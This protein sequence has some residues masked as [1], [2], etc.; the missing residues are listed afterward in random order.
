LKGVVNGSLDGKI[1]TEKFKIKRPFGPATEY[2]KFTIKN[3]FKYVKVDLWYPSIVALKNII[4]AVPGFQGAVGVTFP[5]VDPDLQIFYDDG[6]GWIQTAAASEMAIEYGPHEEAFS[7]VYKPGDWRIGVTN[8]P[9]EGMES[10]IN[11]GPLGMVKWYGSLLDAMKSLLGGVDNFNVEVTKYPGTE[12]I[13][14]DHPEF[15]CRDAVFELTWDNDDV[16]LGLSLIGPSGE[17]IDSVLEKNVDSQEIWIHHVGECLED[18]NYKV[19]VYAL[20]D[21]PFTTDF[22]VRYK[23]NQNITRKEAD[24]VA[25]ACQGAIL[26]SVRNN[27]LLYVKPNKI[28]EST[29]DALLKLGVKNVNVIDLGGYLKKDRIN[30]LKDIVSIKKHFTDYKDIYDEIMEETGSNDVIFSTIDPWSYWWYE[31]KAKLL[32]PAGEFEN[33]FFYGPAA[34]AAAHHGA[35]LLLIDNHKELSGAA[36]WHIDTQQKNGL[37]NVKPVIACMFKTGT[38]IYDFLD[39]WGFDKKGRESIIT[40]AGQYDIGPTWSRNFA[41]VGEPGAFIGTPG[42]TAIHIS[43]NIFYP[44]L[45]Y[46]NPALSP[47]GVTLVNGSKSNRAWGSFKLLDF[48]PLRGILA[49]LGKDTPKLTNL[50]ITR[51]SREENYKFPVLHTYGCYSHRF[52]ERASKYWGVK[53]QTRTGYT[54]GIDLSGEEIDEGTRMIFENKPGSFLPDLSDSVYGPF[55]CTRA[56][57]DSAFSTDFEITMDNLNKGVISWYM[58]LHGWSGDGGILSW[59]SPSGMKGFDLVTGSRPFEKNPWRCYDMLWGSTAE[60]DSATMN[61]KVGFLTGLSG[62]GVPNSGPIRSG[63]LKTGMDI[64]SATLPFP[65]NLPILWLFSQRENYFD[66][67]IAPYSITSFVT[68]FH[69]QHPATEIDEKLD[70]LHSMDFHAGSCLIGCTYLQICLMRHGSPLQEIDPWSTSYWGGYAN[71]QTARDYALGKT[72]GETFTDGINEIGVKYIFEDD[73]ERAWWWDTGENIMIFGDPD[74]RIFVPS[75]KYDSEGKNHWKKEDIK[76][77]TYDSEFITG[78]HMPFGA[79]NYP[80]EKEMQS[81]LQ[82]N[83]FVIVILVLIIILLIAAAAI[84]RKKK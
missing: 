41:G 61:A 2:E 44:A 45:I 3:E 69:F 25:S 72:A 76:S 4:T 64:V 53:Y 65:D 14:P 39:E 13:I 74:L 34:Y 31:K 43:R 70:N 26:G 81:F 56:G 29:K 79:T 51:P 55:Y 38:K 75:T 6:K 19:V 48:H 27:P 49:R 60:P 63:V 54:P 66:G 47:N 46:Q 37:G 7:Y 23:W 24:L 68:K 17:E 50:V 10:V 83:L 22:K 84:S 52:N 8:M 40:V 42:D 12:I 5:S 78:G 67:L 80:H 20:D 62:F 16:D 33:A 82:K 21:V 15:G 77:L 32:K 9:T 30:E 1:E 59:W 71:Q 28:P 58:I 73:E 35:P 18:E 36:V 11:S 57:Y